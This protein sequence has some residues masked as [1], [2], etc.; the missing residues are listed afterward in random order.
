VHDGDAQAGYYT[1]TCIPSLTE[2]TITVI[3]SLM[4]YYMGTKDARGHDG[5]ADET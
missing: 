3:G 2:S 1:E 4:T 5:G